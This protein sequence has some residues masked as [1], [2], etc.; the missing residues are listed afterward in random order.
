MSKKNSN[1]T[2]CCATCIIHTLHCFGK[3]WETGWRYCE[4]AHRC[5]KVGD[6]L[7]LSLAWHRFHHQSTCPPFP[8]RGDSLR[9]FLF[10]RRRWFCSQKRLEWNC[11]WN[12]PRKI[13][14]LNLKSWWFGSDDFPD[15]QGV[16]TLRFQPSIIRGVRGPFLFFSALDLNV[17]ISISVWNDVT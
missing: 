8:S 17:C 2:L 5:N 7:E 15:F 9:I 10:F 3:A 11:G 4:I 1:D 13:N 12:T 16:K 6:S 14:S